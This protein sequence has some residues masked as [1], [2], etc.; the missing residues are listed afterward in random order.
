MGLAMDDL[1]APTIKAGP[2]STSTSKDGPADSPPLETLMAERERIESEL[3]E[4]DAVLKSV[5]SFQADAH[6]ILF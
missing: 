2:V 4:C 1:H 6:I 5:S 3:W